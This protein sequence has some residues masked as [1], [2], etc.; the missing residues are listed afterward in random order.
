MNTLSTNS[1]PTVSG[2]KVDI[3]RGERRWCT[4]RLERDCLMSVHIRLP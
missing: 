4:E 3:S 1:Q 2:F